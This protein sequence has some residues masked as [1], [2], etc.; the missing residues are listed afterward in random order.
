MI[1]LT[2]PVTGVT[3]FVLT[4]QWVQNKKRIGNVCLPKQTLENM[5]RIYFQND[6]DRHKYKQR[7]VF[8]YTEYKSWCG[9]KQ[10]FICY[11]SHP[12]YHNCGEHYDWAIIRDPNGADCRFMDNSELSEQKKAVRHNAV[13]AEQVSYLDWKYG[14]GHV[15][16]RIMALYKSPRSGKEYAIVHACCPWMMLNQERSSVMSELWHLQHMVHACDGRQHP[17]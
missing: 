14:E 3:N 8:G 15:P 6:V 13:P 9:E 5:D 12:N 10:I 16:A 11:R 17:V 4:Y 1:E 2:N 7:T